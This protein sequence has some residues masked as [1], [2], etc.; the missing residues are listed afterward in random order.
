ML[1]VAAPGVARWH[2]RGAHME[3]LPKWWPSG[4]AKLR[5]Y[6]V[7]NGHGPI[8]GSGLGVPV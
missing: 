8:I 6:K 2:R 5:W 1:L 3:H 7:A 4:P